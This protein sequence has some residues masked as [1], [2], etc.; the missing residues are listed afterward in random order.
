MIAKALFTLFVLLQPGPILVDKIAAIVNDEII[1][2]HDIERAI[3]LFPVL[4]QKN[5][6]EENIYFRVLS[7][8][9]NYKVI[10]LEFSD[11]FNLSEE[12]FEQVQ[13]PILK[14]AGSMEKLLAVLNNFT[15]SWSD[16]QNFIREKVLYEKVLREKF[17]LEITI[18]FNEIE[19]FYNDDYVPSQQRLGLAPQTLVE[20]APVIEKYLRQLKTEEQLSAWLNDLRANDK[21]EIKLRSRQ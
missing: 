13:T 4:R 7:D 21:I 16:F 18:P 20:M 9:I 10:F 12:D 2:I 19:N 5:E 17:Q 11:E 6:T 15:M 8:L 1:T 3:A 14:K